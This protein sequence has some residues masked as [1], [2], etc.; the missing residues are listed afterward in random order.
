MMEP[1]ERDEALRHTRQARDPSTTE[2]VRPNVGTSA[3]TRPSSASKTLAL[4]IL[5]GVVVLHARS[6]AVYVSPTGNDTAAGSAAHPFATLERARDAIRAARAGESSPAP[7][8]VWLEPGTYRRT[9]T[10]ALDGRDSNS[11]YRAMPK[12]RV[13]VAGSVAIPNRA[14]E[15][16]RDPAILA[17]LLPS[18][19]GRVKVVD[20][21][22]LGVFDFGRI[23]PRG[24]RR[25]YFPTPLELFVNHRPLTLARWPNA[26]QP[27][28]PIGR[29]I[30]PGSVPRNG[31]LSNRGGTFTF[32]TDRPDRWTHAH[33]IW[34]TGFFGYG[35]ADDTVKIK[36]IDL[37]HHTITTVQPDMY[38]FKSGKPWNTWTAI[39]LLAELDQPGEFYADR[40]TGKLYFLPPAGV[41]LATARLEVSTLN[42]PLVSIEGARHVVLRDL[43][44]ECSRGIGVYMERG[45]DN[46]VEDCTLRGLGIVAVCI[47]RGATPD[48]Y[49]RHNGYVGKPLSGGLGSIDSALYADTTFDRDAGTDQGVV[50]CNI[51]DIGQGAISLGGG[52]RITLTPGDNF[53]TGCRIHDFNRWARTYKGAVNIDGVGN[54]ITHNE[55]YNAPGVAISL[56]GNN[57]LIAYNDIHDVML[58]GNDHG[59][60]YMGRDPSE[61]GNVICYNYWHD[62]GVD[63][64]AYSTYAIYLD[65]A[66]GDGTQVYGNVFYHAGRRAAV[67]INGGNDIT[68]TH[69]VFVDCNAV[70]Q[71]YGPSVWLYKEHR[72]RHRL[73]AVHY[74]R[75]PWTTEY[76]ALASYLA[77]RDR[78]PYHDRLQGNLVVKCNRMVVAA[79]KYIHPVGNLRTDRLPPNIGIR[80][81]VLRMTSGPIAGIPGFPP[82]PFAKIGPE[83]PVP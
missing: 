25:P 14:V 12:A 33:N 27:G 78:M 11:T 3:A 31:D 71:M 51:Y 50:D 48:R 9:A 15:T 76:P 60:F 7:A 59:A 6:L 22:A 74:N 83:R 38:G 75:P 61:R 54:R 41:N 68:V 36:S 67:F 46:R 57:H 62:I 80:G 82:I 5:A 49:F 30:D 69:N 10:F 45:S 65:D 58:D 13:F 16:A 63:P 66:G 26:G 24:F 55:I 47:G 37:R 81:G 53:V 72:F 56:H 29:I 52:N 4:F 18:V 21:H 8:T 43:T 34:I 64:R 40:R 79:A 20:L 73:E 1:F 2:N 39:N 70:L 77:N 28:V 17:R 19:R 35:F 23:G 44:L 42:P 32:S